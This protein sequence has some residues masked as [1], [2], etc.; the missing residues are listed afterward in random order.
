MLS[1]GIGLGHVRRCVDVRCGV[2]ECVCARTCSDTTLVPSKERF[3][4]K[5]TISFEQGY[6][7]TRL[8]QSQLGKYHAKAPELKNTIVKI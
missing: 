3:K 7:T 5:T 1:I 8:V 4:K 2:S 6:V